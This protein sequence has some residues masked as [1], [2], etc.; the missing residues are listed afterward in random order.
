MGTLPLN[1]PNSAVVIKDSAPKLTDKPNHSDNSDSTSNGAVQ[2]A[3]DLA[4]KAKRLQAL[5]AEV[6]RQLRLIVRPLR[7]QKV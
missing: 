6:D 7:H 1:S 2:K 4:A 3:A 5:R